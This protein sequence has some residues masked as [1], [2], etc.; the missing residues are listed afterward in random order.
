MKKTKSKSYYKEQNNEGFL[1]GIIKRVNNSLSDEKYHSEGDLELY[2]VA[3][4]NFD[5][6]QQELKQFKTLNL[7]EIQKA[8]VDLAISL[9][10][11][12]RTQTNNNFLI[13]MLHLKIE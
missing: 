12:I 6:I 5:E 13:Q 1:T 11:S 7:T 4:E 10:D 8:N 9:V 2:E 3:N